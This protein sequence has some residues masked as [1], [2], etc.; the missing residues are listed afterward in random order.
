M[1]DKISLDFD[2][3]ITKPITENIDDDSVLPKHQYIRRYYVRENKS[4]L[5]P[6]LTANM[7]V[8]A[9]NVPIILVDNGIRKLTPREQCFNLQGFQKLASSNHV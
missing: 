4:S 6:T 2:K 3:V 1:C 7:G 5:C 8:G 9:H